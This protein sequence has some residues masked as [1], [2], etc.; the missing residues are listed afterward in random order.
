MILTL[1]HWDLALEAKNYR[2]LTDSK[3][4][5]LLNKEYPVR[6][7][8]P[9]IARNVGSFSTT[10][11]NTEY[12]TTQLSESILELD[13][14]YTHKKYITSSNGDPKKNVKTLYTVKNGPSYGLIISKK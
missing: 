7:D 14:P 2:S 6:H 4:T 8:E 10:S 9:F 3:L 5:P 11:K 13:A 1:K 12:D